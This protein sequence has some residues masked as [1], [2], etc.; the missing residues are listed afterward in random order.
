MLPIL[1]STPF[2]MRN[3]Q[4]DQLW[5]SKWALLASLV[6]HLLVAALVMPRSLISPPKEEREITVELVQLPTPPPKAKAEP[7]PPANEPK[8]EK[9]Q[10]ESAEIPSPTSN[11]G[12]QQGSSPAL[13]PVVLFGDKDRGP[14]ESPDGSSAE[15]GSASPAAR[16][17][18]AKQSLTQKL[19]VTTTRATD[20]VPRATSPKTPTPKPE[21]A[22]EAQQGLKL[23]EAKTLFSQS[24]PVDIIAM[25]AMRNMPR[26]ERVGQLCLTELN[27]QLL[28]ASPAY[29]LELLPRERLEEGTLIEVPRSAF[30]SNSQWYDLS[31]RCEVDTQATKVVGFAFQVGEPVPRSD[32]KSRGLSSQ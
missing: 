4:P 9:P 12:A 29:S 14:R 17:D 11:H 26:G 13:K 20:Q 25:T 24:G 32:W 5:V 22:A 31:Y 1:H 19:A 6:V 15:S 21:D 30:R 10:G 18:P 3:D 27:E 23:H 16:P 28:H 7:S 2:K 8:P